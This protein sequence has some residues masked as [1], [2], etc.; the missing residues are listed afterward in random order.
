MADD[1]G[2][3]P[4]VFELFKKTNYNDKTG[5]FAD[6]HV[7]ATHLWNLYDPYKRLDFTNIT[8][9]KNKADGSFME[10]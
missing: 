2:R 10:T 1:L 8:F 3:E 9:V 5:E 6:H 4:S 7:T